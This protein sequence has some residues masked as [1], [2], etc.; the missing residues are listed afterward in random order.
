MNYFLNIGSNEGNRRLNISRALQ[1]I[2][3]RYGW[4]ET[5]KIMETAPWGYD[6]DNR[7]LNIGVYLVSQEEPEE[8]LGHLQEI[9]RE[10]CNAPHR[11]ADGSYA[12][13][14]IDIDIVAIDELVIDTP[15][16]KVPHP[17]LEKRRFFLQ[18]MTELAP[19]WKHPVTG[20]TCGRMLEI[21]DEIEK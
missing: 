18:P 7:F 17:H 20:L 8:L 11:H 16:L 21:L 13:R 4:V 1:R 19:A 10:L 9:E 6:S 12:D 2:M 3:S 5:S 15:R 14:I